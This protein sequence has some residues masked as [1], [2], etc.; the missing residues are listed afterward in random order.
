MKKVISRLSY[1]FRLSLIIV[2]VAIIPL[3]L[4]GFVYLQNKEKQ[5][6]TEAVLE[7]SSMVEISSNRLNNT[8]LEMKQKCVYLLNNTTVR[9][10]LVNVEDKTL[11]EQLELINI[12]RDTT[13]MVSADNL[14]IKIHWY[15][16][17]IQKSYAE[18]YR[19][20][21]VLLR[22]FQEEELLQ[23]ILHLKT[24]D[25]LVISCSKQ[26]SVQEGYDYI[27]VYTKM[28]ILGEGNYLIELCMPVSKILNIEY[29]EE[30]FSLQELQF[31]KN[32]VL[33]LQIIRKDRM[34]DF[35]LSENNETAQNAWETYQE[36]GQAVGYYEVIS[37]LDSMSE[38]RLVCLL[39]KEYVEMQILSDRVGFVV[40]MI[41][42]LLLVFLTA[43]MAASIFTTQ[44]SAFLDKMNDK[45]NNI[46]DD[47]DE[48]ESFKN[49]FAGIEKKILRLVQNTQE[50]CSAIEKYETENNRLEL[51][52]LQ[53]RFNPHFL[54]N[55]L[56]SIRYQI[57]DVSTKK[58]IDSL[59]K[60]YRIVLSKGHLIIRIDEEIKMI[61][62]Y[63]K[64]VIFTY[65][66]T[67]V[68]YQFEVEDEAKDF[69]IVKHLLQPI[70]ENALEHGL[71]AKKEG[72][73][74]RVRVTLSEKDVVFEIEDNGVGMTPDQ[75]KA[76]LESPACSSIGG[77]YGV[78]NVKQRIETCYGEEYGISFHSKT[79]EGTLVTL[80]IPQRTESMG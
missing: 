72:G 40:I 35:L 28:D 80:R 26:S 68:K 55:T 21:E 39:P 66:M 53:M 59:I 4:F 48:E 18:Y 30:T 77:G 32:T 44:L 38:N 34:F 51:E 74:I 25:M 12:L 5:W 15:S 33:G 54:Y 45:L 3:F 41:M 29:G 63:L 36:Q 27:C 19:P 75:I 62:E 65:Q 67:N 11:R 47:K 76:V 61:E 23:Q 6:K 2:L 57:E 43:Y 46:L 69:M 31:P 24:G 1:R 49:D 60:Y 9:N 22:E 20:I 10:A 70:V 16:D 13:E 73:F 42:L 79:G 17:M 56:T 7:Y 58:S 52:V 8:I 37:E 50:Y 64:I 71:R 14:N 78:F